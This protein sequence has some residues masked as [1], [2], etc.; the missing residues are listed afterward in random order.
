MNVYDEAWK[1]RETRFVDNPSRGIVTG[2][3]EKGTLVQLAWLMGRS[4]HS[5]NRVYAVEKGMLVSK[6]FDESKVEDPRLI[7]YNVMR[8]AKSGF[9]VVSNGDQT[10]TATEVYERPLFNHS[11]YYGESVLRMRHVEHDEPIFTS[12]I[13]AVVPHKG[14]Q[15][16]RFSILKADSLAKARWDVAKANHLY[17]LRRVDAEVDREEVR[18]VVSEKTGLDL[19]RFPTVRQHFDIPLHKEFGYCM[20]TYKPGDSENLPA[21]EG[22]PF[23][24]PTR[25]SL[26]EVMSSFWERLEPQWRVAIGARSINSNGHVKYAEPINRH[27]E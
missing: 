18:A 9:H 19:H 8:S 24:V 11:L 2:M 7:H 4:E 6:A 17:A 20:T 21:F 16:A 27:S 23:L 13:T 5:Q 12:R 14:N 22:E 1:N 26:E 3:D 10:D 25:G 15:L